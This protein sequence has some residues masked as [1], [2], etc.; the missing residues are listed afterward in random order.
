MYSFRENKENINHNIEIIDTMRFLITQAFE[1]IDEF[2]KI[3]HSKKDERTEIS[4]AIKHIGSNVM[5]IILKVF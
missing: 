4:I 5:F 1:A 3:L 2:T